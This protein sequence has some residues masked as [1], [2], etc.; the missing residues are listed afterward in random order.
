MPRTIA[1]HR[2]ATPVATL[3]AMYC[4]TSA[5][6][7]AADVAAAEPAPSTDAG[8]VADGR[9]PLA[10]L[11]QRYAALAARHGWRQETVHAYVDDPGAEISAW[12][13]GRSGEALWILSGIHGEEP[14]GPNAIADNLDALAALA[15]AGVPVVLLPLC[16]PRAYRSNWR[17]PNTPERDW[18]K[19]G[20]SVGDAE[21]L[22]P[23]LDDPAQPRAAAPPGPDTAALTR[24][25]LDLARDYPPRLVL[26][27]HE[28]ELSTEGGYIYSQGTRPDDS[29]AGAEIIRLLQSAGIPIRR[30]G[31]TRFGEPIAGGVISRDA[32]GAPIRDGSIDELLSAATVRVDGA[33]A[34]GPAAP[35]VIVVETPAFAGSRFELRVAAQ[36]AVV[37][38]VAALWRLSPPRPPLTS[39]GTRTAGDAH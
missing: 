36:G 15:E 33:S 22:L 23:G 6:T 12:R 32:D 19:G 21:Y 10:Q 3:V 13:T 5:S 31:L 38:N 28:D 37:K 29:P 1:L 9:A 39:G 17:Y 14:A 35:T 8:Y 20:Y 27:L 26:D 34:R 11:S 25:V 7:L 16:N 30:S 2:L 4:A 18:R 24:Y